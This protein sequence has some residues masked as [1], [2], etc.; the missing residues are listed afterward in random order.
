VELNKPI[1]D[2][3]VFAIYDLGFVARCALAED[4]SGEPRFS[5]I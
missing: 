4:D 2:A 1:F 3:I 5:K